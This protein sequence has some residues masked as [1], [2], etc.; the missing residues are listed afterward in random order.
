MDSLL[1]LA[2]SGAGIGGGATIAFLFIRWVV[3]YLGGRMEK[4]ADRLDAG[5]ATL[6]GQLQ[7]QVAALLERE[8]HREQRLRNVEDELTECKRRHAESDAELMRLKAIQQGRGEMR[9]RAQVIVSAEAF[10][11]RRNPEKKQ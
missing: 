8:K 6:I 4:R 7:G 1:S 11:A 2:A 3:E 5:T 9:D 10:E